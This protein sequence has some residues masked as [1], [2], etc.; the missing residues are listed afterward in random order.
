MNRI[1]LPCLLALPLSSCVAFDPQNAAGHPVTA[2]RMAREVC[3][4][5]RAVA[6]PDEGH[7]GAQLVG[8]Q[9]HVWLKDHGGT[10]SCSLAMVT[11]E[12]NSGVT[13]D[14]GIC[15]TF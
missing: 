10:P 9:W 4:M 12:R 11:V 1:V 14:C 7:W 8:N 2:I 5:A 13:S 6:M 15:P 3:S